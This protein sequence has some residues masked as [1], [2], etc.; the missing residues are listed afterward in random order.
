MCRPAFCASEVLKGYDILHCRHINKLANKANSGRGVNVLTWAKTLPIKIYFPNVPM[1]T[2]EI[3]EHQLDFKQMVVS[4]E[5][6]AWQPHQELLRGKT[7]QVRYLIP[8]T[9]SWITVNLIPKSNTKQD[10]W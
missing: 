10:F 7:V 2:L 8:V 9:F 3:S 4:Y 6:W 5:S 1:S